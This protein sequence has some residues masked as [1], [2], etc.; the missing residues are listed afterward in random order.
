[1]ENANKLEVAQTIGAFVAVGATESETWTSVALLSFVTE[2]ITRRE[3]TATP[4][5]PGNCREPKRAV[6]CKGIE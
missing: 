6:C 4:K 2:V 5:F 3:E 1:M